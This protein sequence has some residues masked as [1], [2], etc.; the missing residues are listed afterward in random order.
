MCKIHTL[1]HP[2]VIGRSIQNSHDMTSV[3]KLNI[4]LS[5]VIMTASYLLPSSRVYSFWPPWQEA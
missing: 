4:P 3:T 1:K 2:A 5:T